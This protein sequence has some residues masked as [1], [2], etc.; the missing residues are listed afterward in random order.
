M[1]LGHP[2]E[3]LEKVTFCT[4]A[5][6]RRSY[7][8]IL[9]KKFTFFLRFFRSPKNPKNPKLA[10]LKNVKNSLFFNTG[11]FKTQQTPPKKPLFFTFGRFLNFDPL[12]DPDPVFLLKKTLFIGPRPT[13]IFNQTSGP[14]ALSHAPAVRPCRRHAVRSPGPIWDPGTA[15]RRPRLV[16]FI[17]YLFKNKQPLLYF[18]SQESLFLEMIYLFSQ[19]K[20][21][22]ADITT[23]LVEKKI[24]PYPFW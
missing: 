1:G 5:I 6:G 16:S 24:E 11:L 20:V 21:A 8:A 18:L 14:A 23:C 3:V 2:N 22:E 13:P 19:K 9:K 10:K 7:L 17:H 12:P 15:V 4:L